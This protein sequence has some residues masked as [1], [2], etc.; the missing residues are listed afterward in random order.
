MTNFI[1]LSLANHKNNLIK[2]LHLSLIFF[3][4]TM[5]LFKTYCAISCL[6]FSVYS[7]EGYSQTWR[8]KKVET[9]EKYEYVGPFYEGRARVKLERKWGFI[10]T[11]GRVIVPPTRYDQVENFSGGLARVR[12]SQKGWGLVNVEG[13]EILKPMFDYISEF[14]NG[15]AIVRVGKDEAVIDTNGN[16]LR[17]K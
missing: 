6:L 8:G 16:K 5:N 17:K 3:F 11:V 4:K 7:S 14:I 15:E 9:R 10:D 12:V 2:L 13:K 1:Y